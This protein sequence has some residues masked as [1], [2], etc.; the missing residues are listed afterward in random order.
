VILVRNA[1]NAV[2]AV[3]GAAVDVKRTGAGF[4]P[5][6]EYRTSPDSP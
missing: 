6:G 4:P 3:T 2:N 5:E 1:V